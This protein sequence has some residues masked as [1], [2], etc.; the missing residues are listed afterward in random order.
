[1]EEMNQFE[2]QLQSW[3]PRRPSPK[4]ARRLFGVANK[5]ALGPHRAHA[6]S[7][8]TPLAACAL[9]FLVAVHSGTRSSAQLAARTNGAI[10]ATFMLEAAGSSNLATYSVS[11]MDE[12]LE[13][14]VWPHSG[15]HEGEIAQA[16]P[17]AGFNLPNLIPTNR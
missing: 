12:N 10:F 4:I 9:T 13:W 16:E 1:M 8:L 3:T 15:H 6:W 14:T 17:S 5:A 7:W 11:Q 2:K